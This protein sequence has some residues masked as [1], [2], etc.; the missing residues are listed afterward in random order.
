MVHQSESG[1]AGRG[2]T[3]VVVASG[4]SEG[5][6]PS[7]IERA[8]MALEYLECCAD[9]SGSGSGALPRMISDHLLEMLAPDLEHSF[10][11][12]LKKQVLEEVQ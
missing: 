8:D 10:N 5:G 2:D 12:D 3:D 6:L 11:A 4:A 7:R 9:A 1:G